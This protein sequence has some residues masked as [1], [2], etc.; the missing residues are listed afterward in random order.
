VNNYRNWKVELFCPSSTLGASSAESIFIKLVR[1]GKILKRQKNEPNLRFL[2]QTIR[3][4]QPVVV[5]VEH[6]V[7]KQLYFAIILARCI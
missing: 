7:Q 6:I 5:E 2:A 1:S 4:W 3:K